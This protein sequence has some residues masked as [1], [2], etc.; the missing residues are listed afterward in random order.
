MRSTIPR[1]HALSTSG[2]KRGSICSSWLAKQPLRFCICER[3]KTKVSAWECTSARGVPIQLGSTG[4]YEWWARRHPPFTCATAHAINLV[5]STSHPSLS[6]V[7]HPTN[8]SQ[9]VNQY[10]QPAL[11]CEQ[12]T[13]RLSFMAIETSVSGYR[14]FP[15]SNHRGFAISLWSKQIGS[16]A[17]CSFFRHYRVDIDT[18]EGFFF[19]KKK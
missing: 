9:K 16:L 12:S 10:G 18:I 8:R 2:E 5:G 1:P 13:A 3:E 4:D 7:V 19:L 15:C 17:G 14:I 11:M 6:K